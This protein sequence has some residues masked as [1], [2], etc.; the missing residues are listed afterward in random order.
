MENMKK[1]AKFWKSG[2]FYSALFMLCGV[3]QYQCSIGN[4]DNEIG[5]EKFIQLKNIS[6]G[7]ILL[8]DFPLLSILD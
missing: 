1:T 4:K 6:V 5:F 2:R 3:I 8:V 7:R